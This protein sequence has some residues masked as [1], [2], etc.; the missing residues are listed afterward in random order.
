MGDRT[1]TEPPIAT[2]AEVDAR[3]KPLA[4]TWRHAK[5]LAPGQLPEIRR[6]ADRLLDLRL[7]IERHGGRL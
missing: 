4:A 5:R 1:T 7:D 2:V 3:L 6:Q